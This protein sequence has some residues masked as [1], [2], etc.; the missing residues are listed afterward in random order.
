MTLLKHL[1]NEKSA[2]AETP[3]MRHPASRPAPQARIPG[4]LIHTIIRPALLLI[5]LLFSSF[6]ALAYGCKVDGI[7]YDITPANRTASVTRGSYSGDVVIPESITYD[8]TTYSIISIGY[9]AFER[10]TGL[11]SVII[12]NSVSSIGS[13]AFYGCTGLTSVIIPNS[14]TT[15]GKGAFF[16]CSGLTSVIVDK[17][18]GTYDSRN[19][20]NAIIETS[21]SKLIVGSNN[22]LIPNSVTSIGDC[23]FYN[24]SGLTSATIPNSVTAIGDYAFYNCSGLTSATIPNSVTAIGYGAFSGCYGL[25]SVTIPNSVTTIDV[26]TFLGCSGLTSATIPNSVTSIGIGA[27]ANCSG[28]T[29]ITIPN[30]VTS[31][32]GNEYNAGAFA[33]CSG[34]TSVTIPNSVITIGSCA[35]YNC[36]GLTSV[37]IGSSVSTIGNCVFSGC[38]ELTSITIPSSVTSI[39]KAVFAD[40]EKLECIVVASENMAY[41]SRN[42]CNAIIESTQ[43]ELISA[44]NNTIIPN[45]VT[46]IGEN[47]FTSCTKLTSILI[48]NSVVKIGV[49]AFIGC[50]GLTSINIPNSVTSIGEY[51]FDVCSGLNSVVVDK[52][53]GRYDSRDNCNAIIETHTNKLV[54]GC[55]NTI[56][57]NSV[58][59]IGDGA[60][61]RCF[62][63]TS[64]TIPN[65]VTSIGNWA[66]FGCSGLTSVTFNAEKCIEMGSNNYPVFYACNNL[67]SLTIGDK[68]TTIP[69]YAFYHCSKLTELI[70]LAV[71][72]P[73]CGEGAFEE[74]DKTACRLFVPKESVNKYKVA[75]QWKEFVYISEYDGV[76]D[77]SVD[78]QDAVYEVYNLQGVRVGSG[79]HETEVTADILPHGV[80]ILVS[81]QGRKKLK[82]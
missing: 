61:S 11:T 10:C 69:D 17:N 55:K 3:A 63:L 31:I 78:T 74:V 41:D 58:T 80:Y 51:A 47:A 68:V 72:P 56:I 38:K 43:N 13:G 5:L 53:N 20:C 66:F 8:N 6:S 40:C 60:F 14:V 21:T 44:C 2:Y 27:F 15:I 49:R 59:S 76:D 4:H 16:D 82:I 23:A 73:T 42:E 81:P 25:T 46:S 39:G 18:N 57:P 50:D 36:T 24:C 7:Y 22:T 79:L 48:P 35:F 75:D 19:N 28:L 67:T 64:V 32:G 30:S 54:V 33:N 9:S 71:A 77:V 34:L 26:A 45:S 29:S 52:D 65:S 70:S 62:G 1:K 12:P 37:T